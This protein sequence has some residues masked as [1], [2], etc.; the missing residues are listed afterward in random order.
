MQPG[1]HIDGP[2]GANR[3]WPMGMCWLIALTLV[4]L[5]QVPVQAQTQAQTQTQAQA[6]ASE[7]AAL[8]GDIERLL[9]GVVKVRMQAVDKA[10]S[11]A[12]L[13]TSREGS[14][15]LIDGQGHVL[16]I[17]YLVSE[18]QTI[19]LT[20]RSG[21]LVPARLVAYDHPSGLG[22]L[23]ALAPLDATPFQLGSSKDLALRDPLMILPAG[24]RDAASAALLIDRR[25]FSASWEYLLED[26]LF[27]SPPTLQWAG[28]ALVNRDGQLL[29]IGSLLVR[30]SAGAGSGVPGNMFVPIDTLKAILPDLLARGRRAD[31]PRPWLGLATET[32]QGRLLVTRVSPEGPADQAG[33][34]AGDIVLGI[35]ADTVASHEQLYRRLWQQ[36]AGAVITLRVLQGPELRQIPVQSIDRVQYF[37]QG[38]VY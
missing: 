37:R 30:D 38:T 5:V 26:A 3:L 21:K 13:G 18:A 22:L 16:T 12:T 14:G 36:P 20:T 34:R 6:Q 17:G 2:N 1:Q 24:G 15:V 31:A 27:T 29:G 25:T 9:S 28:A 19:E 4:A 8:P 11:S 33:V 32:V 10:R 35:G 7:Q 23:Q